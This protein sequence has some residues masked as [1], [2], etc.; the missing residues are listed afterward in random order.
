MSLLNGMNGMLTN[1]AAMEAATEDLLFEMEYALEADELIDVMVDGKD[2]ISEMVDEDEEEDELNQELDA[3]ECCEALTGQAF[4]DS[5]NLDNDDPITTKNG[6]IGQQ[7]SAP[8][9]DKNFSDELDDNNDPIKTENGSIGQKDS[10]AT[11]DKN[12]SSDDVDKNDPIDTK[13]GSIGQKTSTP[14]DP[15]MESM[16]FFG[17]LLDEEVA[18][19]GMIAKYK[20]HKKEKAAAKRA[21]SLSSIGVEDIDTSKVQE[22]MNQ[23]Q[24]DKA[25]K[26]ASNFNKK[27]ESAKAAIA[28]DDPE[29]SKKKKTIEKLL[30]T[31]SALMISIEHAKRSDKYQKDGMDAKSANKQAK[32]ELKKRASEFGDKAQESLF[33]ECLDMIAAFEQ[34]TDPEA[35][36]DGSIGQKDSAATSDKNFSDGKLDNND[37]VKTKD[38]AEGQEDSAATFD[39][40]FSDGK[41]DENDPVKTEDGSVGQKD[42]TAKD[43]ASESATDIDDELDMLNNSLIDEFDSFLIED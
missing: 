24:Y 32:K 22:L 20:E 17:E 3:E 33:N 29:S 41:L 31:N 2:E 30:K 34:E 38:G 12:F 21:T 4:L 15:T 8:S 18:M 19:E 40:N 14:K 28:E 39:K 1:E 35:T 11:F 27:L 10:A 16:T 9:F 13:N 25:A 42:S 7:D 43:P 26:L 23:G 5:L 6:S 36:T 37:P